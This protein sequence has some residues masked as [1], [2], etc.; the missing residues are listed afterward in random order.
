M[1]NLTRLATE[2]LSPNVPAITCMDVLD[3]AAYE[4]E[5]FVGS[6]VG[7]INTSV[8]RVFGFTTSDELVQLS[9][10]KM[11]FGASPFT[12]EFWGESTFTGGSDTILLNTNRMSAHEATGALVEGPSITDHGV[13]LGNIRWPAGR[14]FLS[15]AS[16]MWTFKRNSQYLFKMKNDSGQNTAL[17]ASLG[18][19][20][21][22][23][24]GNVDPD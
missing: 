24:H 20:E 21:C 17:S 8:E 18:W 13:L 9:I 4:G 6:H 10:F 3:R 22:H 2:I 5:Q 1:K 14:A 12:L 19:A 16:G 7:T 23:T 11:T 15:H